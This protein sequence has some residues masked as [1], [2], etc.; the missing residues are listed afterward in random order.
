[1]R[2]RPPVGSTVTVTAFSHQDGGGK[3]VFYTG[4]VTKHWGRRHV[5]Y[6]RVKKINDELIKPGSSIRLCVSHVD[7]I[8]DE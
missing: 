4:E 6:L 3:P 7:R 5:F 1:M 8:I 2:E